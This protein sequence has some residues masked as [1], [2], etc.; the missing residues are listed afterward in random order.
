MPR[1]GYFLASEENDPREIVRQARLAEE[2]GFDCLWI[3]D[4][5][6]PWLEEQ[7]QSGFAWSMIGAISQVCSLPVTTAVTCPTIRMHPVITAQAAATSTLLT[8]GKFALGAG[9]G[10]VLNEHVTGAAW[11]PGC[12]PCPPS[13][14]LSTCRASARSRP[15][16]PAGSVTATS[17]CSPDQDLVRL[18]RESGGDGKPAQGGLKVCWGQDESAARKTMHRLWPT[19]VIPGESAQLL[20]LPRHFA[21]LSGLV[22]ED[23]ITALC[24][25]DPAVH[26]AG[27]RP[28]LDAGYD[29]V[30]VGQ[31]GPETDGFF[32]FYAET[33]LPR[34]RDEA[35]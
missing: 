6:H 17:A 28:Y 12:T 30:Y 19:D 31:V 25:P 2:A 33:V 5:F 26:L 7:G 27:V 4:H 35:A 29:E 16:W 9:S 20:P 34:L 10:E 15:G 1:F 8:Q 24:G 32:E 23:M 11:P 3:S 21:Q 14:R 18:F 13:R 22:S